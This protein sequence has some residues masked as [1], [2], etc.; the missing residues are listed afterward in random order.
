MA[1][2][3]SGFERGLGIIIGAIVFV[4]CVCTDWR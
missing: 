2:R 1:R 3:Q 4:W